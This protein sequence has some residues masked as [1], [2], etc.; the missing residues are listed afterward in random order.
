[1]DESSAT[2]Q[3]WH[4]RALVLWLNADLIVHGLTDALLATE[5]P[6]CGLDRDV[7]KEKLNLLQFSSGCRVASMTGK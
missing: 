1:M 7:T 6:L 3:L 5:V 2:R 4:S